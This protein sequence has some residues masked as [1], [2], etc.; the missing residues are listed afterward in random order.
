MMPLLMRLSLCPRPLKRHPECNELMALFVSEV[1]RRRRVRKVSSSIRSARKNMNSG[2]RLNEFVSTGRG[3]I[4]VCLLSAWLGAYPGAAWAK[5]QACITDLRAQAPKHGLSV[6]DFDRLTQDVA[7]LETTARAARSQAEVQEPW[8][9][10]IAKTVDEERVADGLGILKQY[11]AELAQIARRYQ[12]DPAALVAIFGIETDYGKQLGRTD[13]LN[14][15]L[16]RACLEKRP[17]WVSNV[18][19]SLRLLRDGVVARDTF[20]GS[21]SGAFGMTQFIP[22][23]FYEL[24]VDG[25]G[26]GRVDLYSSLPDALASTANHLRKRGSRWTPGVPAVIEIELP[27]QL[28]ASVPQEVDRSYAQKER[29][30]SLTE[31]SQRGVQRADGRSL[32][33]RAQWPNLQPEQRAYLFVP[34]GRDGPVFLATN[35]FDAILHYNRSE[36]Y[37]LAVALLLNRL[38]GDATLIK[39]WPTDDPGLSRQQIRVLQRL[40]LRRGHDIGTP[41]GIPGHRTRDAVRAEQTRLGLTPDGRPGLQVLTRLQ[42]ELEHVQ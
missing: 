38:Q 30:L 20:V 42:Q 29:R 34:T 12:T 18:F 24:A 40:L 28:R 27:P 13:V 32:L 1:Q 33:T 3:F 17:L 5:T 7:L 41:D 31:W 4:I 14:A 10:Y 19:A 16:T 15:W 6:A 8:W 35:N 37:A 23:S 25:D 22:T 26:D 2:A 39:S 36:K 9:D 21:W 11:D